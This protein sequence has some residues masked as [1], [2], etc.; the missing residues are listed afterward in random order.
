M[1]SIRKTLEAIINRLLEEEEDLFI[2]DLAEQAISHR[3]AVLLENEFP[4]WHV[5]CEYNRDQDTVKKL[6]YAIS[7]HEQIEERNVV[8]DIIIHKRMTTNNLLVMEIKK[9]TNQEPD[10]RDIA[11]LNAF[12]EQLGYQEALFLRF[13]TGNATPGIQRLEWI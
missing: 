2:N 6:M 3:L 11:K 7:P 8:P 13:V 1:A 9:S 4:D 10:D 12:K 5:D